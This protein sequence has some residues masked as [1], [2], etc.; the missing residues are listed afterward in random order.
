MVDV[1]AKAGADVNQAT[2]K[3]CQWC[4]KKVLLALYLY[5]SVSLLKFA[6]IF[7]PRRLY[8]VRVT[9]VHGSGLSVSQ[10]VSQSISQYLTSQ[11]EQSS[12]KRTCILSGI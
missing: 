5:L 10:S 1:L 4:W 12:Y 9:V 8:A 3:V 7:S 2:T 6:F 11:N